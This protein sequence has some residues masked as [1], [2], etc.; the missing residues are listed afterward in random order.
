MISSLPIVALLLA[1]PTVG[2]DASPTE[3]STSTTAVDTV[4][5]EVDHSALLDQQMAEAAEASAR[6]VREDGIKAL[7]ERHGIAVVDD[8]GAPAVVVKLSWKDYENSV[9]RIEISVRR[10][11]EPLRLVEAFEANCINDT[12]LANAVV[13][14]LGAALAQLDEAK[15]VPAEDDPGEAD[16]AVVSPQEPKDRGSAPLGVMGKAGI[17]LLAGGVAGV[18]AGGIVFAQGRKPDNP[19]DPGLE[20]AG[21]DFR[22][23]GVAVMVTGGVLAATGAVLLVVDRLRARK[24]GS[25]SA[26]LRVLPGGPSIVLTAKF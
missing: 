17:G 10:P 18:V 8:R 14:K 23:P 3:R 22:S 19:S 6:F 16:P 2:A 5:L 13:A 15:P 25:D 4:R 20:P 9:Y 21:R 1:G 12:A 24:A 7:D 26:R 11:D